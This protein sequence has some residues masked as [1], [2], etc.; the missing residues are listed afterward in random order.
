MG[1]VHG[2]PH[3][4]HGACRGHC[5]ASASLDLASLATRP[6][7]GSRLCSIPTT[8]TLRSAIRLR[9]KL[10][11]TW[12]FKMCTAASPLAKASVPGAA[13]E[14]VLKAAPEAV[15]KAVLKAALWL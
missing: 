12:A 15:L 8:Y 2:S 1:Q 11:T 14:A 9:T 10:T 7:H 3:L 5:E 13:P 4:Q 6:A